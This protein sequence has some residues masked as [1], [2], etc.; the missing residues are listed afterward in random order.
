[1]LIST[2]LLIRFRPTLLALCTLHT[3]S[4]GSELSL[5]RS[6]L[7]KYHKPNEYKKIVGKMPI[8]AKLQRAS[9]LVP[10]TIKNG[11]TYF[12]LTQRTL[13]MR[14]YGGQVCFIGGMRD[15]KDCNE[16][17]TAYREAEEEVGMLNQDITLLAQMSPLMTTNVGRDSFL[18]TP[19]VVYY[20]NNSFQAKLNKSEVECLHELP[21]ERF[22]SKRSH[23]I[24]ELHLENVEYYLHYFDENINLKDSQQELCIFGITSL[25]A[26]IVSVAIHQREAEF[27]IDPQLKLKPDNINEFMNEFLLVKSANVI[28][29]LVKY[30]NKRPV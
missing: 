5:L 1:M 17:T 12:M 16:I 30:Y 11:R 29:S 6:R 13:N 19:V 24:H 28:E 20:D 25:V 9:L 10:I 23:E 15:E 8:I 21:T 2:K 18:L 26:I 27:N 14:N 7:A 22:L 4:N 3:K